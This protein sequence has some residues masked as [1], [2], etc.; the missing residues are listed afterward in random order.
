[1]KAENFRNTENERSFVQKHINIIYDDWQWEHA[2]VEGD[3]ASRIGRQGGKSE[4]EAL[5]LGLFC[6]RY[7]P[8]KPGLHLLITGGVERQAYELYMKLRRWMEAVAPQE[9]IGRPSMR[10]MV[11][12]SGLVVLSLPCGRD[13]SGLRNYAIA[14][15]AVD[16]AH[17][18]PDEVFVALRPMLI[19]TMGSMDLT[20]TTKG[21][22]GFFR[23]AFEKDSGFTTLHKKTLDIY[24]ERK[25][26]DTWTEAQKIFSLE[27]LEKEKKRMTKAQ[28]RQEY[29]AE[30]LDSLMEFFPTK[31][32][33][34]CILKES[35]IV[36]GRNF[37]GVD[38]AGY[39]GDENAFVTL[40]NK[41]KISYLKEYF[42]TERVAAWE[43]V[44][45]IKQLNEKHN[46]KKIGVDDGGLGTPILDY[47]LTNN[48]LKRKTLG[49]N[50][51][52]REVTVDGKS[53]KL[54]KEDMY[55]NLKIMMEQG[56]IKF[57]ESESLR[58]SL[59]S[60]QF[61]IDENTKNVK[62]FGKY[63]HITEG[64]VR[65]AW[66]VKSKGL[67]ILAFC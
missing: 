13:G 8:P 34:S 43:T 61:E 54:L 9:I 60:I 57:P 1:M 5:K 24:N 29:E 18:V 39:G 44:K 58:A 23:E 62:I 56:L 67:N 22:K 48:K 59:S 41:G 14:K 51:A 36:N 31:L 6:M 2:Q 10:K 45:E 25:I 63:S 4:D 32:I 42:T 52:S 27:F 26:S 28:F 7:K 37:L 50:N 3:T 11:L 12:K 19:T 30:F 33:D 16:E 15:L 65:A 38:F 40:E 66:L 35:N 20:S 55:G 64:L 53:K 49:L 47:L 21:A 46:Y 17:Y